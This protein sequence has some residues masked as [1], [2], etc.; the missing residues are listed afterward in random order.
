MT[1]LEHA[2]GQGW[3]IYP[4][5]GATGEAYYAVDHSGNQRLFIKRNS[6]PFLAVLSAEGIV[7]KLLWT[8]RLESGDVIIAQTWVQGRQ[9]KGLE[10]NDHC[11]ST[12]L[13]KIHHSSELLNMLKRIGKTPL[14]PEDILN[15]IIRKTNELNENDNL[16]IKDAISYLQT[17][18]AEV[19]VDVK[20]VVCHCDVNHNNWI[21]SDEGDIFLIDWDGAMIADPALDIGMLL[22]S[23]VPFEEWGSWLKQYGVELT[24]DLKKKMHWYVVAQTILSLL[25]YVGRDSTAEVQAATDRLEQILTNKQ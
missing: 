9:L 25:W 7:P 17:S 14:T 21:M 19:K 18:I 22:Y 10:M 16:I 2:L 13:R 5:G 4:A 12:I 3:S 15:R 11:T 8:K 6:S 20:Y 23:Y 1:D 24:D